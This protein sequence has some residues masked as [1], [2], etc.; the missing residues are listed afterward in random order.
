MSKAPKQGGGV[1]CE[2]TAAPQCSLLGQSRAVIVNIQRK[3]R[4]VRASS[5]SLRLS[6]EQPCA[7]AQQCPRHNPSWRERERVGWW[8]MQPHRHAPV[9][10]LLPAAL[11]L[12]HFPIRHANTTTTTTQNLIS[13]QEIGGVHEWWP[14]RAS[15][16]VRAPHHHDEKYGKTNTRRKVVICKFVVIAS[17]VLN[18]WTNWGTN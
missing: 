17:C 4:W 16:T 10:R 7:V 11:N 2:S 15:F 18:L 3:E 8:F 13:C 12:V 9:H 14:G 1:R 6:L 5:A